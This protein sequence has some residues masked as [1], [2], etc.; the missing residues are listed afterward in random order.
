MTHADT[1]QPP[2]VGLPHGIGISFVLDWEDLPIPPRSR[3]LL[4]REE[5][6]PQVVPRVRLTRLAETSLGVLYRNDEPRPH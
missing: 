4:L 2:L 3:Y 1:L 5:D 6:E